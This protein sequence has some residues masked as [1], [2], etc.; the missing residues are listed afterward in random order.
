MSKPCPPTCQPGRSRARHRLSAL[1]PAR[2]VARCATNTGVTAGQQQQQQQRRSPVGRWRGRRW[3]LLAGGRLALCLGLAA[4]SR[5]PGPAE[6][7]PSQ[8][9]ILAS[10]FGAVF[11]ANQALHACCQGPRQGRPHLSQPANKVPWPAVSRRRGAVHRRCRGAPCPFPPAAAD[12]ARWHGLLR[13]LR[14]LRA[15]GPV[16]QLC[17]EQEGGVLCRPAILG[18]THTRH[19]GQAGSGVGRAKSEWKQTTRR[20]RNAFK[21]GPC[22]GNTGVCLRLAAGLVKSIPSAVAVG[23]LTYYYYCLAQPPPQQT[24]SW[25]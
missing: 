11:T 13:R 8:S 1:P 2:T 14:L 6:T 3:R 24:G 20:V 23:K 9:G 5:P 17:V 15:V 12:V 16:N 10:A 25:C 22:C 4:V 21:A 19:L 18:A 7:V